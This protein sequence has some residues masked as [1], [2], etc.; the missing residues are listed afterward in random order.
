VRM[1][2]GFVLLSLSGPIQKAIIHRHV[3]TRTVQWYLGWGRT[4]REK[5]NHLFLL[6]LIFRGMNVPLL[7][8]HIK[9]EM[10]F[11]LCEHFFSVLC[12]GRVNFE[13]ILD[14]QLSP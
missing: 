5:C 9:S 7:K 13:L 10:F 11:R 2:E 6:L 1:W 4:W 12:G 14:I 3:R 8:K